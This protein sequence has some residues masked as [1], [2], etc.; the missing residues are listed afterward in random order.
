MSDAA[1]SA[2]PPASEGPLRGREL[3][4][5]R[6]ARHRRTWTAAAILLALVF[7]VLGGL[8]VIPF[9]VTGAIPP[10]AFEAEPMPLGAVS[11]VLIATFALTAALT[12]GWSALF[13]RRPPAANGLNARPWRRFLRGYALGL[14]FLLSVV[15]V[16]ALFGGYQV[17]AAG[18]WRSPAAFGAILMLFIGFVI[19]GSTEEIVFRGWIMSLIASR[20]GIWIAVAVNSLIFSLVHAANIEPSRELVFGLINI[21]LVGVFLS[22]YAAK[23]GSIWG[24][25][26]WH[27]AWNWLLG[28]GFGIEVSG[29]ILDVRPLIIDLA[30]D[31]EALWWLTG[32]DFGPEASLVTTLVLL[33]GVIFLAV[34]G[35]YASRGLAPQPSR[36]L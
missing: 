27:A 30:R 6:A 12:L 1:E 4:A 17:E 21:V 8:A 13:E 20:H 34:R 33:G 2:A 9:I 18:V 24:V 22:L 26:G 5:P 36:A 23:E 19:Q 16:V 35:G 11:V 31:A 28:V 32:G 3:Y 25:C 10:R 29:Q 14:A 15:G 7:I